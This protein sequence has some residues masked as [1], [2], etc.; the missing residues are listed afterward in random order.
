[1]GILLYLMVILYIPLPVGQ[2]P[3][4]FFRTEEFLAAVPGSNK[5]LNLCYHSL[6]LPPPQLPK[7]LNFVNSRA[8]GLFWGSSA[9]TSWCH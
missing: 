7:A 6:Q 9:L 5:E 3:G 1:M 4:E 2:H 8:Q